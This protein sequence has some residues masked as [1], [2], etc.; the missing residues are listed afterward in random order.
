MI[1]IGGGYVI[2]FLPNSDDKKDE[3][4]HYYDHIGSLLI[5]VGL[6]GC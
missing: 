2:K 1:I 5:A 6:T 3:D 4:V